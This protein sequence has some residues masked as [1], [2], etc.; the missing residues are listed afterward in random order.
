MSRTSCNKSATLTAAQIRAGRAL[1]DWSRDI[2]A[3]RSGVSPR[4]LASIESDEGAPKPETIDRIRNA[5]TSEG[6]EF[7]LKNGGGPGVRLKGRHP[8]NKLR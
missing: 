3:E 4:T 1:L 2:L 5:F 7:I 6:I 8:K